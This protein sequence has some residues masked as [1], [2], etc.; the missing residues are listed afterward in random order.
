MAWPMPA[1]STDRFTHL[2]FHPRE[3]VAEWFARPGAVRR[4]TPGLLPLMPVREADNLAD[5]TTVFSMPAG[6]KWVARHDRGEYVPGHR[7]ADYV[8]N[9]PFRRT[10][11]WRHIHRFEDVRGPGEDH[12]A[13]WTNVIDEVTSRLPRRSIAGVFAYRAAILEGDMSAAARLAD[14]PRKTIAVTGATGTVG[15]MLC[16]LLST[17][18]HDVVKLTRSPSAEPGTRTWSPGAPAPGLLDGIDVLIHL[19]GAPIAG[20]FT[21]RHLA[22]VRDSRVGPSRALAE[23]AAGSG[24]EAIVSASAV[25]Y[26]GADRGS[27]LLDE[28]ASSG[29]GPLADIVR[30]WEAAWDPAR[31]AGIRVACIRTGIVQAGGG[32][33]LPLLARLTATGLGGRLGDG[34]QWFP[35]IALDD[36]LDIYH[37]AALEPAWSGPVNAVS[38]G[39]VDNAEFTETL[40]AVLRRPAVIP[41][42][43]AAPSILLGGRG[44]EE[45]AFANQ[46]VV[47]R[48]LEDAGHVFRFPDL[49][50]ALR[51][52][53]LRN[54]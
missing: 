32:G 44:A 12:P 17:S 6:A 20:R 53:L 1:P 45:L 4:L 16:A 52:E 10:L 49:G 47:P 38:P 13:W 9:Q 22:K 36:L 35:W 29:D 21:D 50:S 8:A 14:H 26:Y 40:A 24:V 41:V 48:A 3:R 34:D 46:R 23:L 39:G 2:L 42:P 33:V 5:G 15:S 7:F 31:E 28:D 51:H 11:A 18:G 37:R 30:D 27:E 19:A 25:G 43:K 54:G